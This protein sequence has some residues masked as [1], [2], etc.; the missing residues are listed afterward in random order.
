[1][2][3][4]TIRGAAEQLAVSRT[5]LYALLGSGELQSIR[6]GGRRVI[7]DTEL[8]RFIAERVAEANASEAA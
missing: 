3:C 1:M 4:Y 8:N 2:K 5:T 7:T 6:V